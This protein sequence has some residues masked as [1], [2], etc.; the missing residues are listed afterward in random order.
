MK[1]YGKLQPKIG[2]QLSPKEGVS[3]P[4]L[5]G[6]HISH[7]DS[8]LETIK[9][10]HKKYNAN[11]FQFFLTSP[12][13]KL[14]QVAKKKLDEMNEIKKYVMEKKINLY[15]HTS[16]TLNFANNPKT[17]DP[18]WIDSLIKELKYGE[19]MGVKA[20]V[21]HLGKQKELTKKEAYLNMFKSLKKVINH[22]NDQVKILLETSSGEGSELGHN[23]EEFS[24]FY[25]LFPKK[26]K[27]RLGI[28]VDTCHIFSAG[29]DIR[30]KDKVDK[31]FKLL[32]KLFGIENIELIHF[33]DSKKSLG[34]RVDRHEVIGRG[35]IRSGLKYFAKKTF[36]FNIPLLFE[37]PQDNFK[38]DLEYVGISY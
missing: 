17:N 28:C 34:S 2:L 15:I 4:P 18:Y 16:Y 29:Y 22:T 5:F 25:K 24:K 37:T 33:N 13:R 6:L 19:K 1:I 12:K 36:E 35:K 8:L 3:K 31:F 9:D 23:I 21:L 20:C 32:E 7:F 30:T 14:F 11:C 26:Y 10:Y 27:D 38:K